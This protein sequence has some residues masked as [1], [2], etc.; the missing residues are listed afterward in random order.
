M[1]NA[2][3]SSSQAAKRPKVAIVN[4]Q[5]QSKLSVIPCGV[6]K[7]HLSPCLTFE[8][9]VALASTA[10]KWQAQFKLLAPSQYAAWI[11]YI[12]IRIDINRNFMHA[13]KKDLSVRKVDSLRE[14]IKKHRN[15][16]LPKALADFM[17]E[18]IGAQRFGEHQSQ[19][20]SF[21]RNVPGQLPEDSLIEAMLD[22]RF[23][24]SI[25][26]H[27]DPK[28]LTYLKNI[29]QLLVKSQNQAAA[30]ARKKQEEKEAA[31][32]AA[33]TKGKKKKLPR[34]S[35][36][37][38]LDEDEICEITNVENAISSLFFLMQVFFSQSQRAPLLANT[39][40]P[41]ALNLHQ[42]D[43]YKKLYKSFLG[44]KPNE[45]FHCSATDCKTMQHPHHHRKD[46]DANGNHQVI[47][48]Y[49]MQCDQHN[50][51]L[52][53][54]ETSLIKLWGFT[55]S[56]IQPFL[57][58]RY[59]TTYNYFLF[60]EVL[61]ARLALPWNRS[62]S[63]VRLSVHDTGA[64][65][66]LPQCL[67]MMVKIDVQPDGHKFNYFACHIENAAEL[68]K[69]LRPFIDAQ[70]NVDIENL[71][72]VCPKYQTL[73]ANN[74]GIQRPRYTFVKEK[75]YLQESKAPAERKKKVKKSP[76]RANHVGAAGSQNSSSSNNSHSVPM[77]DA[78]PALLNFAGA[79]DN[80][81]NSN[82]NYVPMNN[83]PALLNFAAAQNSN[84][85][86]SN[87]VLMSDAQAAP[88]F[89]GAQNNDPNNSNYIPMSDVSAFPD[90]AD[91]QNN[92]SSGSDSLPVSGAGFGGGRN[93]PMLGFSLF[94]EG[95]DLISHA[96]M[97]LGPEDMFDIDQFL[98]MGYIGSPKHG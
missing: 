86:N 89:A 97:D 79:Q 5:S 55:N 95:A 16:N 93:S 31:M 82:G 70:G 65:F 59:A 72:A 7:G 26:H 51:K 36:E 75:I 14:E 39:E 21:Y 60:E 2:R 17:Y 90:F 42:K 23:N 68:W 15:Q 91:S 76:S 30:D 10:Q 49:F 83:A 22:S 38:S 78:P 80:N 48:P 64:F 71:K 63:R 37:E 43:Q 28:K 92:N 58:W 67:A 62:Q 13:Y 46:Q 33:I 54:G 52:L 41:L 12:K 81:S 29:Q 77:N 20:L 9:A 98:N 24:Y 18:E 8:D 47:T 19:Y 66:Q 74:E 40:F 88:N 50:E 44:F 69:T 35:K 84:S 34:D 56:Q 45:K 27:A 53:L 57:K 3:S 25:I 61:A 32:K 87:D 4:P 94:A 11:E 96:A 85:N 73:F 6:Y 1:S